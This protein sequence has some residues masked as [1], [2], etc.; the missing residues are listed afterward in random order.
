LLI[1]FVESI[2]QLREKYNAISFRQGILGNKVPI[3]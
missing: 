3:L 2:L 1:P